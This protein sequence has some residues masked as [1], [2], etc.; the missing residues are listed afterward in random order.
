MNHTRLFRIQ[1]TSLLTT[2]LGSRAVTLYLEG[3]VP[4]ATEGIDCSMKR[5]LARAIG[6][7]RPIARTC[8]LGNRE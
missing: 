2:L 3:A 5:R 4:V 6:A 1:D 8:F 7:L